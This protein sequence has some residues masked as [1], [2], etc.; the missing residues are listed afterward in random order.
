AMLEKDVF[1]KL[2]AEGRLYGYPFSGQ[3]FD[4]GTL[5]RYER[6]IKEWKDLD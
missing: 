5:E 1:P 4:T 3:W 2:A 6:A